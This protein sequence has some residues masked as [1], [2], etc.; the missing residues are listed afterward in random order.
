MNIQPFLSLTTSQRKAWLAVM[1]TE[2]LPSS[3]T[4]LL[5]RVMPVWD[6]I[7]TSDPWR[8]YDLFEHILELGVHDAA[9][10]PIFGTDWEAVRAGAA[11]EDKP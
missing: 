3:R 5:Q 1:G 4:E 10:D 9:N 7:K 8:A 2:R 6:N 11:V